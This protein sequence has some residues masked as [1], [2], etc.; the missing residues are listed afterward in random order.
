V[1][2]AKWIRKNR[3]LLIAFGASLVMHLAATGGI[4]GWFVART[5]VVAAQ[6]EAVL[7]SAKTSAE[8]PLSLRNDRPNT[9]PSGRQTTPRRRAPKSEATFAAPENTI[10]VDRPVNADGADVAGEASAIGGKLAE[11]AAR[12]ERPGTAPAVTEVTP[13]AIEKPASPETLPAVPATAQVVELPSRVWIAFHATTSV[14]DGVAHYNWK[15]EGT[16]YSFE[17]TIQAT[18]FF[19][20]MFVGTIT[21][22][23]T[24]EVTAAGI[25]PGMFTIRRGDREPET[26]EFQR[27]T[28]EVKL[29]RGSETRQ[30]P[31]PANLQDT[32]SFLFQLAVEAPKLKTAED[33]LTISV[34]NARGINRYTFKKVGEAV[35][36]T[37]LGAVETVHLARETSEPRDGYEAWLSPKHH[38]LP[39]KL[40]F[41]LDRFPAELI[42][43]N[44]TSKP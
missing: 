25:E 8:V 13:V 38:Y 26:A 11:D 18:G 2:P 36:E 34:T 12:P 4:F 30:I 32:Q 27:A 31:M 22:Q 5:P 35:L 28:N 40:R 41:F 17:S 6:F 9:A 20:E 33:R 14:A 3:T 7:I 24:G 21:Q 43:T 42:A 16:K 23:S 29:S 37:R 19:V 44:I 10:A 1:R 15:R 39:V